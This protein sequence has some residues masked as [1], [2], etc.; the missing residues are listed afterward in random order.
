VRNGQ[1]L[2]ALLGYQFER[3][4]HDGHGDPS[5]NQYIPFFRAQYPLLADKITPGEDGSPVETKESRNVLDGYALVEAAFLRA[6]PLPYPYGVEGLPSDPASAHALAIQAEVVRLNDSLDAIADLLLAE[7]VFQVTQGNFERAA[8]SLKT[9]TEGGL[10]P[11]PEIVQTPRSGAPITQRVALHLP[12][13]ADPAFWPGVPTERARIESGL[14]RWL[15]EH[16]PAPERIAFKV[17]WEGHAPEEQTLALLAW[18]PIDL[19]LMSGDELSGQETELEKRLAYALRRAQNDDALLVTFEFMAQPA[20]PSNFSLFELLPL[21]RSLRNLAT[22]VRPLSALD[23]RLPSEAN[24]NP[25]E[26]LNP[27]GY[28]LIELDSRVQAVLTRFT[29]VLGNLAAAIPLDADQKPV[30][31][32]IDAETVRNA[33]LD[34]SGFGLSDAVPLSAVGNTESKRQS[35]ADQ[36]LRL[37]AQCAEKVTRG[38]A[39]YSSAADPNQ[40]AAARLQ[41]YR[42]AAQEVFGP[43][44]NLAPRFTL[45]NTAEIQA[46]AAFRDLPPYQGLTRFHQDNPLLLDEWLQG[47]A[48]ARQALAGLE[49]VFILAELVAD[50]IDILKP[51]QLPFHAGDHWVA[52]EFPAV[53]PEQIGQEGVFYPQSEF[54]S[55]VQCLPGGSF[56]PAADQC[57]LLIDEWSE[58]IPGPIETTGIA[59]HYNQPSTEPPQVLLLALTPEITGQWTWAKLEGILHD[60]LERAKQRA[61]EP[62]LLNGTAYGHLLPAVLTAVTTRRFA[63]ITTD[64]VYATTKLEE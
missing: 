59:V 58:V 64:L 55:L 63:T 56:D 1:E 5:L 61:V 53:L 62:D 35:L 39:A 44:F 29:D 40:S 32:S 47:I 4:L 17:S 31:D 33:L 18:Q 36:G 46:A 30:L 16:L 45:A 42:L 8:A 60:T 57:G 2:G 15:G 38:T 48:R 25:A 41:S 54:V 7:G 10:P 24:T 52:V 3:G 9:L 20:D 14:N 43:S 50:P 51:L 12:A 37:L 28:D 13:G 26:D 34:V 27:Q 23:F 21:L 22:T 49:Q 11:D 6:S 19:V